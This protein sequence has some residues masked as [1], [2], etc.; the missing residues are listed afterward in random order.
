MSP[1]KRLAFS[2]IKRI[3]VSLNKRLAVSPIKRLS[4]SPIRKVS[5]VS[6]K[7]KLNR[8]NFNDD[9]TFK[10]KIITDFERISPLFLSDPPL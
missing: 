6:N 1:I 2:P 9:D 7:E 5:W 4:V 10:A 8:W 3:A